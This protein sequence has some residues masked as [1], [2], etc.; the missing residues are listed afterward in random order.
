[1]FSKILK[2]K[3][4]SANDELAQRVSKM[5]LTD[6]RVYVNNRLQDFEIT[7]DGLVEVLK[8]L[9]EKNE[10]TL[11]GYLKEDDMDVKIKKGFDLVI[12]ICA[13]KKITI[14][15]VALVQ[16]FIAMYASL[17]EKYDTEHKEIYQSRLVDAFNRAISNYEDLENIKRKIIVTGE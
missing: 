5:N 15:A 6:M 14:K 7:E 9:T 8:R 13:N 12:S 4:E 10:D 11:E 2:K 1:M 3:E 17:I 16:Q